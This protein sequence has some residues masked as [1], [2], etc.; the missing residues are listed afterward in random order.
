VTR[1]LDSRSH[2]ARGPAIRTAAR[3][4]LTPATLEGLPKTGPTDP[5]EYYRRPLVGR[6]FRERINMGL[7]L[8]ADRRCRRVLEVGYGAEPCC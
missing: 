1:W 7:R 6:I 4:T 5:I 8:L 2:G 3:L